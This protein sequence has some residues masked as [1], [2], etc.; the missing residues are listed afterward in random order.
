MNEEELEVL[1]IEQIARIDELMKQQKEAIVL[2]PK[3]YDDIDYWDCGPGWY[4]L[5]IEMSEKLEVL[6]EKEEDQE[7]FP[8]ASQVKEKFGT[9][10]FYMLTETPEM[11]DI[12]AEYEEK[13]SCICELCGQEGTLQSKRNW[14]VTR[15]PECLKDE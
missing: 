2:F 4:P 8:C 11:T 14:W 12:I 5:L 3:L 13:S 6:I 1:K 9:L 15:C 7:F 10:H